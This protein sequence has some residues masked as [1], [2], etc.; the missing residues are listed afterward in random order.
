VKKK[1]LR[2]EAEELDALLI[3][4]KSYRLLGQF[5][6]GD[7]GFVH[8]D[9][10]DSLLLSSLV[11][12]R[13][14]FPVDI[15]QAKDESGYWHRR[16][17]SLPECYP[18]HSKSSMSR[19]M[20]IGLLVHATFKNNH[21]AWSTLNS[22]QNQNYVMGVGDPSRLIMMPGLERSF[23]KLSGSNSTISKS[24][25]PWNGKLKGYAVKLELLHIMCLGK[26]DGGITESALACLKKYSDSSKD[27]ILA[28]LLYSLY[29]GDQ[30]ALKQATSLL[31][32]E[33]LFPKN[34]LPTSKDRSVDWYFNAQNPNDVAPSDDDEI[35]E[36]PGMD[37]LFYMWVLKYV[38]NIME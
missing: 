4:E 3:Q 17:L 36:H 5:H 19:D 13:K 29:S 8:T 30:S 31:L 6:R 18:E 20:L 1:Y 14:D 37:F 32:N 21:L 7:Y 11:G 22:I 9:R 16:P 27:D 23:S 12:C 24:Y 33:K 35:S 28:L 34:R 2:I 15:I 10:C 26:I 38:L 25:Q